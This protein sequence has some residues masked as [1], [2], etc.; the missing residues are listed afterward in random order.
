MKTTLTVKHEDAT[1]GKAF[2]TVNITEYIEYKVVVTFG[3]EHFECLQP[4]VTSDGTHTQIKIAT[5][6]PTLDDALQKIENA[7]IKEYDTLIQRS[8]AMWK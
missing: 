6:A 4:I 3:Y 1:H 8:I 5:Y 2:Y 7:K